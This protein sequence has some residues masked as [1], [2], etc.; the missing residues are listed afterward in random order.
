MADVEPSPTRGASPRRVLSTRELN[1]ALLARQ[2]LLDRRPLPAADAIERLVGMQAQEPQ[3]P[4]IGLWSRLEGFDPHELSELITGRRAVRGALMRCTVHLVTTRDWAALSPL[5]R[6]V[7]ARTFKGSQ[8]SKQIATLDL[9]ELLDA[10]RKLLAAQPRTRAE[11]ARLLAGRWP[12][13]DPT[14]MAHAATLLTPVV[15]V[16]PRGLWRQAGQA[17][18]A[19]ADSWLGRGGNEPVQIDAVILRYLSAYGPASTQDIQA[20]CGLTRLGEATE[21]LRPQLRALADE[22]GRELFDVPGAPLPDPDTP[23]PPRF[24]A[25][26]DNVQLAHGERSRIIDPAHRDLVYRDRLMRTFLIDGFIAGTWSL[27][28][29]TLAITP[30]R[31]LHTAHRAALEDEA[32][33]LLAFLLPN[34]QHPRIRVDRVMF[35]G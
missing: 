17:R 9:D 11:L 23:A 27:D 29:T 18:W 13:V 35:S 21:R 6:P 15:Q 2:M 7:L 16:P 30:I 8:F 14:A 28:D 34:A 26:F 22:H 24:L 10:A 5:M 19:P 32:R 4:Y 12:G 25:P 33:C 31:P 20:W 1:R 3:A